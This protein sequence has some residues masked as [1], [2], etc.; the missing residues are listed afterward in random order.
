MS[1][2][3]T[4]I[5]KCISNEETENKTYNLTNQRTLSHPNSLLERD[6]KKSAEF[7]KSL[8]QYLHRVEHKTLYWKHFKHRNIEKVQT[9]KCF[10]SENLL[11]Y[12]K[13]LA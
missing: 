4:Y 7:D 9:Q 8:K 5:K 2:A 11:V 6:Y 12:V 1:N 10:L 13:C 3:A